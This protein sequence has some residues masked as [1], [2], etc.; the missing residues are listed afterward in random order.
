MLTQHEK[1]KIFANLHVKGN[2]LILVNIW[3]AGTAQALQESVPAIATSSYSVAK[4]H[5]Y[6]DGEQIP[7]DLVVANLRR[8]VAGTDLPVTADIEGGYSRD[9][10]GLQ[11]TIKQ[12][13]ATGVVG[14]NFEDQI[15]GG[16]GLYTIDEQVQRI[17][18]IREVADNAGVPLFINARTDVFFQQSQSDYSSA[19]LEEVIER[20]NAY[21]GASAD[22]IF[23]PGLQDAEFIKKLCATVSLPVNIM[24]TPKTLSIAQL[25]ALGVS[26]IS[27]GPYPY[28]DMLAQLKA[29]YTESSIA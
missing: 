21:A 19:H 5:G 4:A 26:R 27:Y 14:I 20:A 29:T 13:I 8:I 23:V 7:L 28:F 22:G 11:A 17:T 10:D 24:F 1:A 18:A 6:D 2:P 16:E 25:S 12:I 15:V 3:D 9:I